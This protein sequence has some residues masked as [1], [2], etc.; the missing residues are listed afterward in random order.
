[1][2]KKMRFRRG[3]AQMWAD[4]ICEDFKNWKWD[5]GAELNEFVMNIDKIRNSKTE[6]HEIEVD[7]Y[8]RGIKIDGWGLKD[9]EQYLMHEYEILHMMVDAS[10]P[11]EEF[12]NKLVDLFKENGYD[13]SDESK[14]KIK[15]CL[16]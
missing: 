5:S 15:S 8:G 9:K 4:T 16:K 14:E 3:M 7:Q 11:E 2:I 1:M 12:M 13:L 10:N 6:I